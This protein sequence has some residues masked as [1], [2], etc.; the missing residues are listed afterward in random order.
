MPCLS[1]STC[2]A[3]SG[4]PTR[5]TRRAPGTAVPPRAWRGPQ[6]RQGGVAADIGAPAPTQPSRGGRGAQP[7]EFPLP[8]GRGRAD[9]CRLHHRAAR[10]VGGQQPRQELADLR[11]TTRPRLHHPPVRSGELGSRDHADLAASALVF[12]RRLCKPH[13]NAICSRSWA[14]PMHREVTH[15]R[16]HRASFNGTSREATPSFDVTVTLFADECYGVERTKWRESSPSRPAAGGKSAR[17]ISH[18][19]FRALRRRSEVGISTRFRHPFCFCGRDKISKS[20]T[21]NIAVRSPKNKKI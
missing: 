20:L 18:K 15:N 11:P 9:R 16:F 10:E 4:P 5:S 6:G 19:D 3:E 21:N 14:V 2:R 13:L 12:L 8:S 7:G 1:P 17:I